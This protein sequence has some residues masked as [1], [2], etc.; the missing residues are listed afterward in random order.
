PVPAPRSGATI[1]FAPPAATLSN[2]ALSALMTQSAS[3]SPRETSSAPSEIPT[4][5]WSVRPPL[6]ISNLTVAFVLPSS[7]SDARFDRSLKNSAVASA[8]PLPPGPLPR[9]DAPRARL[10]LSAAENRNVAPRRPEHITRFG[11]L[12]PDRTTRRDGEQGRGHPGDDGLTPVE[13][14]SRYRRR[15][16][17]NQSA[18][19]AT[20]SATMPAASTRSISPP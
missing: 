11:R 17:S 9:H 4:S 6:A 3:P 13:G 12:P 18:T 10:W 15:R 20:T 16:S 2:A 19:S 14:P 1:G 5:Q 8:I 7:G